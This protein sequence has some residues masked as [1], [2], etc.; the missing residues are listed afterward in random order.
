MQTVQTSPD[1]G[2]KLS[3]SGAAMG[4]AAE[5]SSSETPG[6]RDPMKFS[7]G[8]VSLDRAVELNGGHFVLANIDLLFDKSF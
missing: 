8:D 4:T 1:T 5:F 3:G 2:V 6:W 7:N